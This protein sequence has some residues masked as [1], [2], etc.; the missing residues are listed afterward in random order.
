MLAKT[1]VGIHEPK[2][3]YGPLRDELH[4][5]DNAIANAFVDGTSAM[6]NHVSVM[7]VAI[8]LAI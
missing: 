1:L 2:A 3:I 7:Y 8:A 5:V 6:T 4:L